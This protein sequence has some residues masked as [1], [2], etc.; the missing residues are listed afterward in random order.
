MDLN[1]DS[2]INP[3]L[4]CIYMI[5]IKESIRRIK[6]LH[7]YKEILSVHKTNT[8]YLHQ[9]KDVVIQSMYQNRQWN[10]QKKRT[11]L[12]EKI[13]SYPNGIVKKKTYSRAYFK[14]VELSTYI[15]DFLVQEKPLR[16]L[17][18]AEAPGGFVQGIM[19]IRDKLSQS[20]DWS[21]FDYY[22][23]NTLPSDGQNPDWAEELHTN[24][25]VKLVYGDLLKEDI[26]NPDGYGK[27]DLITGDCG[28]DVSDN[29]HLQE[30]LMYPLLIAQIEGMLRNIVT[31][32]CFILK[33]FETDMY[34]TKEIMYLL[35]CL[36]RQVI[37]VKPRTSRP[38]NSEKYL[39]CRNM[40]LKCDTIKTKLADTLKEYR[41]RPKIQR[42]SLWM[43][44]IPED[45]LYLFHGYSR[46]CKEISRR[47]LQLIMKKMDDSVIRLQ[48][49]TAMIICDELG[50]DRISNLP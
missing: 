42:G 19:D 21:M 16:V 2:I 32:G 45:C 48:Y 39:V 5:P 18:L 12:F 27:F 11:N 35:G 22:V 40:I 17:S 26:V 6:N 43:Q 33:I 23:A 30:T 8:N 7:F 36:F 1:E 41:N 49:A 24:F 9:K 10:Y 15:T 28:I 47:H 29:F 34:H 50:L 44:S 37:I 46:Y 31:G 25:R 13:N 38:L 20:K 14:L 4:S 3:T